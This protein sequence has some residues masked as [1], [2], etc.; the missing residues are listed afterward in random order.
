MPEQSGVAQ[1]PPGPPEEQADRI[2][3]DQERR[4]RRARRTRVVKV[5]AL[6]TVVVILVIFV[7]ANANPVRVSYV[8]V[9]GRPR[10]IWVM[11]ACAFLGGI[12]G[13]AIGRPGRELRR[14]RR[15]TGSEPQR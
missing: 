6:L 11:L 14:G 13:Y 3:T 10:L 5:L 8:F 2:R 9:H 7:V 12:I 4:I 15:G 1:R